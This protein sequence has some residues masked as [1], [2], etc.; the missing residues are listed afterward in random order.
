M[1]T[2]APFFIS[3]MASVLVTTP[4]SGQSS[5]LKAPKWLQRQP[6]SDPENLMKLDH[7]H[8]TRAFSLGSDNRD[9]DSRSVPCSRPAVQMG[10]LRFLPQFPSVE[11][12]ARQSSRECVQVET[13][14]SYGV[15]GC[16]RQA[17][18]GS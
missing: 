11:I 2:S 10:E 5:R 17:L 15:H 7:L 14:S 12:Q 4:L 8:V 3:Q 18:N 9:F 13:G 6:P 1:P 16:P